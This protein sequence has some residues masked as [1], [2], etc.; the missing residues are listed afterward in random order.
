MD[1]GSSK[2]L[3]L[4]LSEIQ[5]VENYAGFFKSHPKI[6]LH[7]LLPDNASSEPASASSTSSSHG[8]WK[9]PICDHMNSTQT[10]KCQECGVASVRAD[11]QLQCPACTFLNKAS[12]SKC[13]ICSTSLEENSVSRPTT[14]SMHRKAQLLK[15]A[16]RSGGQP[17]FQQKLHEAMTAQQ[18]L[19]KEVTQRLANASLTELRQSSTLGGVSGIIRTVESAQQQTDQSLGQAFQDLKTLMK[20]AAEMV[21]LA[22]SISS[23]LAQDSSTDNSEAKELQGYMFNLGISSSPVTR[24][25]SGAVYSQELARE[26]LEFISPHLDRA[27]GMMSLVD[28][29]CVVNRARGVALLSPDDLYKACQEFERLNLPL[30]IRKFDSGLLVVQSTRFDEKQMQKRITDLINTNKKIAAS[31]LA[32]AGNMSLPI[33]AEEL[34]VCLYAYLCLTCRCRS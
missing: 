33:A 29:Y 7:V 34:L 27:G 9:C 24:E 23:K 11:V 1:A 2:S 16:F 31:D 17:A 8:M 30:K 12:S 3:E 18:W 26:L 15:Y 14:A 19:V 32:R 21:T 28:I 4:S 6:L 5:R 20:K 22:E 25:N 10:S 13:E